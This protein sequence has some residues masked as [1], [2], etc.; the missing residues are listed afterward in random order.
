MDLEQK[1]TFECGH[2]EEISTSVFFNFS[3]S[4]P[5]YPTLSVP[6]EK[7]FLPVAVLQSLA[8]LTHDI[9]TETEQFP[10]VN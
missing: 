7:D 10:Q 3:S 1:V 8:Q 6:P 4:F 9:G 5:A 2:S